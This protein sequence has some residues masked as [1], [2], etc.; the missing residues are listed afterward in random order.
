MANTDNLRNLLIEKIMSIRNL[1]FLK[2]LDKIIDSAH[3]TDDLP[4]SKEQILMLKMSDSDITNGKIFD[5]N[6]LDKDDLKWLKGK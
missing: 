2:A 3:I 4:L 6:D 5:Q 1:E